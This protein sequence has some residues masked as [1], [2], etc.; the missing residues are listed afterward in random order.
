[1]E[2]FL[3]LACDFEHSPDGGLRSMP[4]S[5]SFDAIAIAA[6]LVETPPPGLQS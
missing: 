1:L 6:Q 3:F 5:F 2:P 4:L